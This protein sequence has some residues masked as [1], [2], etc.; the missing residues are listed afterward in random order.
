MIIVI[1]RSQAPVKVIISASRSSRA[2]L[3]TACPDTK[4]ILKTDG[5]EGF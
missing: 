4:K 1:V 5:L 3:T 2:Q